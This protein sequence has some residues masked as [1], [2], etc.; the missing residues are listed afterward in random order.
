MS[1]AAYGRTSLA[2]ETAYLPNS[3]KEYKK[4]VTE[5]CEKDD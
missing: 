5:K 1:S 2:V 4:N 3:V